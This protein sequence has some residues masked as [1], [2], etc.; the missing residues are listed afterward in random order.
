M[1]K[2]K[3]IINRLS[4]EKL[5]V[6]KPILSEEQYEELQN[7][8]FNHIFTTLYE[9]IIAFILGIIIAAIL[10]SNKILAK[11]ITFNTNNKYGI[12]PQKSISYDAVSSSFRKTW[13]E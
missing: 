1:D 13:M 4:K 2:I 11:I 3:E 12:F 9:V 8:L 10:W 6:N 7:N 5:K